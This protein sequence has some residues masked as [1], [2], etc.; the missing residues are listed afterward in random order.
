MFNVIVMA[1]DG[2]EE[3]ERIVPLGVALAKQNGASLV[4]AHVDE[5]TIGK[6][7]GSLNALEQ[8]FEQALNA[9]AKEISE[10]EGIETSVHLGTV[11][12][13]GPAHAISEI[14]DEADA[15]LILCGTRG[16]SRVGGL[17]LGSVT[18][19]LLQIAHQPVL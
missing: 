18:Q 15:D 16:H 10:Q 4:I 9:R 6:G 5:R 14:A 19:R 8:D 2:S 17:L 11:M 1:L 13:G 7:G 12:A 3:S